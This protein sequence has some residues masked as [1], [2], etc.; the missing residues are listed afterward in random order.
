M[1]DEP[2]EPVGDHEEVARRCNRGYAR[3]GQPVKP[4]AFLATRRPHRIS[5][6]RL[7]RCEPWVDHC[8]DVAKR[9]FA[10][11]KAGVV[12]ERIE[13]ADVRQQGDDV[14]HANVVVAPPGVEDTAFETLEDLKGDARLWDRH[15]LVLDSLAEMARALTPPA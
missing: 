8:D 6:H 12:R 15:S 7:S 1:S 10:V 11:V 9:G 5:T 14:S 4:Q 2:L 3:P 13:N